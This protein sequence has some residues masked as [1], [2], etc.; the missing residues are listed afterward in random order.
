MLVQ[1]IQ[2]YNTIKCTILTVIWIC[3]TSCPIFI[4]VRIFGKTRSF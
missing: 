4:C 2:L 3:N 1:F